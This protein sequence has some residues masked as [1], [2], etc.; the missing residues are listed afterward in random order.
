MSGTHK[1][2]PSAASLSE[3][4]RDLGYSAETAV[5][6]IIDNSIT[7]GALSV[8]IYCV[9]TGEVPFLAVLDDGSGMTTE[10]L[11]VAMKPGSISPKVKRKPN[12]LGRFGIGLKTASFSQCRQLTVITSKNGVR[13]AAQ[14]DLDLVEEHDD[15]LISILDEHEIDQF[16]FADQIGTDGTLVVWKKMDRLFENH[17]GKVRDEIVNQKLSGLNRHLSLVFH[18]YLS[19]EY[20]KSPKIKISVNGHE[21]EPFDP[22]CLNN[23]ATQHLPEEKIR[24]GNDKVVIQ[25]YI[26]PHHSKLSAREYDFYQDR[27]DFISNQG[28]YIYRNGRLMAWGDWFRL[29]PKN[30]A[31]KL[32]RVR[33]DFQNSM[34]ESWT[35]DIKKSKARP[36]RQVMERVKQIINQITGRSIGVHKKRGQRLFDETKAPVWERFADSGKVRYEINYD[37]PLLKSLDNGLNDVQRDLFSSIIASIAASLPLEMI[38]SD[39]SASPKEIERLEISPDEGIAQLELIAQSIFP[40]GNFDKDFFLNVIQST[41]LFDNKDDM[42]ADFIGG[43]A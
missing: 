14:W 10:E 40:D 36:P 4:M 7:A 29:V 28:A 8:E 23:K 43:K 21:V 3:T 1:L 41:R 35:I 20:S 30:E 18:R 13:S 42:V 12:D 2:P 19:G 37:H 9:L 31:T 11:M 24:I 27:S 17:S 15:W 16:D 38:Y 33:I 32:A 5:A 6:D 34:D 22:F 25:P 39:Y 26:L